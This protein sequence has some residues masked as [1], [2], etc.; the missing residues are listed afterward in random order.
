VDEVAGG[1]NLKASEDDHG[2]E[3]LESSFYQ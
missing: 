2:G 1:Y 3:L